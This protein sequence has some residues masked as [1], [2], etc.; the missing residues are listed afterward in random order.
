MEGPNV[1]R[2]GRLDAEGSFD[3]LMRLADSW[4]ARWDRR[5]RFGW[6]F[7]LAAWATMTTALAC[8]YCGIAFP[9]A[10]P[11]LIFFAQAYVVTRLHLKNADDDNVVLQ[12]RREAEAMAHRPPT[13][14]GRPQSAAG[15]RTVARALTDNSV[16]AQIA[17]AACAALVLTEGLWSGTLQ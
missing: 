10:L 3:A 13:L 7:T 9:I 5:R 8:A 16:V 6:R 11:A 12:L 17:P 14:P 2:E 1:V 4:Q 15:W